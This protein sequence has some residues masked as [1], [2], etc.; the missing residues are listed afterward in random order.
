MED[1]LHLKRHIPQSRPQKPLTLSGELV[2]TL[3]QDFCRAARATAWWSL[4][5]HKPLLRCW[6]KEPRSIRDQLASVRDRIMLRC[7]AVTLSVWLRLDLGND[8]CMVLERGKLPGIVLLTEVSFGE[9]GEITL[10]SWWSPV[11]PG[12]ASSLVAIS[13][14]LLVKHRKNAF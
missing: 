4:I 11:I 2:Q 12:Q 10:L 7:N 9:T 14:L 6:C 3:Q 13:D 1:L 8:P 5:N